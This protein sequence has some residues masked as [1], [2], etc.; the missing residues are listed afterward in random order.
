MPAAAPPPPRK[1]KRL[2]GAKGSEGEK[3]SKGS[4]GE[5]SS[6]DKGPSKGPKGRRRWAGTE[7]G[8]DGEGG[9]ASGGRCL[10]FARHFGGV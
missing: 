1:Q 10:H 7:E 3:S 4:E 6:K 8:A 5:K 2:Q 9:G